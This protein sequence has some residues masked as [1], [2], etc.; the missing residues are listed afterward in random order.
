MEGLK[1]QG[2]VVLD[3]N[4]EELKQKLEE[5]GANKIYEDIDAGATLDSASQVSTSISYKLGKADL[6]IHRL[7]LI[8][9]FLNIKMGPLEEEYHLNEVINTLGLADHQ[10]VAMGIEE[11]YR[12]YGID[13]SHTYQIEPL[14]ENQSEPH[15]GS[16]R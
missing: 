2:V 14:E 9:P 8:P 12:L 5:M 11:I 7:P 4:V 1:K 3:V 10:M 15:K 16:G 6:D 13:D